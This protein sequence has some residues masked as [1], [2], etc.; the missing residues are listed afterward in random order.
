V[1]CS[2]T[3]NSRGHPACAGG[4]PP[5]PFA[6]PRRRPECN[7]RRA[8]HASKRRPPAHLADARRKVAAL[9]NA[10]ELDAAEEDV[11]RQCPIVGFGVRSG[12]HR[13]AS[14]KRPWRRRLRSSRLARVQ[15]RP[16]RATVAR[17]A[18]LLEGTV[19]RQAEAQVVLAPGRS[20][21]TYAARLELVSGTAEAFLACG[22]AGGPRRARLNSSLISSSRNRRLR[23]RRTAR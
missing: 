3:V 13:S 10:P 1:R 22:I 9:L 19:A 11:R 8:A 14:L 5:R 4:E 18:D 21:L 2:G 23:W 7:T 12:S 20:T 6:T 15:A 16:D 17:P